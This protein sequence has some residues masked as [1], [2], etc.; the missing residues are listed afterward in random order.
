MCELVPQAD[1]LHVFDRYV[2]NANRV[3]GG[4][5]MRQYRTGNTIAAGGCV[6]STVTLK[7]GT[8]IGDVPVVKE[9]GCYA[10]YS[11]DRQRIYVASLS[12]NNGEDGETYVACCLI[13]FCS[14]CSMLFVCV[15]CSS[16]DPC[17]TFVLLRPLSMSH[18]EQNLVHPRCVP[19]ATT[20]PGH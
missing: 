13:L 9:K 19:L 17:Y 4:V 12:A 2:L 6:S 3:M 14:L 5:R 1:P 8:A 11:M 15:P 18:Y 16:Y 10:D 7:D 20:V